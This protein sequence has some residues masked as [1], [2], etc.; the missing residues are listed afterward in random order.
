MLYLQTG[1]YIQIFKNSTGIA[2]ELLESFKLILSEIWKTATCLSKTKDKIQERN[3]L[4]LYQV[5]RQRLAINE[6]VTYVSRNS[7]ASL[8]IVDHVHIRYWN[9]KLLLFSISK[10]LYSAYNAQQWNKSIQW[11][12]NLQI[13]PRPMGTKHANSEGIFHRE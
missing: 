2:T 8:L 1:S 12:H 3:Y 7:D 13:R 10:L 4:I 9:C 11:S 6:V 5:R